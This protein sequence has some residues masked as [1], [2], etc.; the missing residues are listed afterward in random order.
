MHYC[1][2]CQK[3]VELKAK[4]SWVWFFV[5]LFT[6]GVGALIYVV[7]FLT[8]KTKTKCCICGKELV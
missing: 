3:E 8:M 4:F 6:T 7:Y 1:E 5:H 2:N